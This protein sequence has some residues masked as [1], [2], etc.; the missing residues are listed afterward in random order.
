MVK[1]PD[2]F[3]AGPTASGKSELALRVAEKIGAEICSMDAFQIYRGLDVGTGKLTPSERKGI[4]HHLLDIAGP[5]ESFSVAD[6]LRKAGEIHAGLRL[7]CKPVVWVGGTGLYF[8]ALRQGLSPVPSSD[9]AL[10]RELSGWTLDELQKE[11]RNLDP[12]W[13]RTADL[14]NPRRVIRA[15]AVV[16]QTGRPLSS[17][18]QIKGQGV[19]DG[20]Q[21]YFLQPGLEELKKAIQTRVVAMWQAGW[22]DEVNGLSKMEGWTSSQSSR[23]LGYSQV[24][25]YLAG[26]LTQ[27]ACV[28]NIQLKTWQY[29]RR[30]LT[31]FRGESGMTMYDPG[32]GLQTLVQ[33]IDK[34]TKSQL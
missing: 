2:I 10:I 18:H 11:I 12:L 33:D 20:G 7:R 32:V 31:W 21:F 26:S 5:L 19:V 23:A 8:R 9:P 3:I 15:L 14:H 17:W 16:K 27:E 24:L 34:R 30:Q 28:E 25:S 6:Y 13:A 4:P 1:P 29:A 22:A